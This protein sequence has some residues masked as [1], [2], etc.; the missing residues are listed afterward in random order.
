MT[1][2]SRRWFP[3]AILLLAQR[4]GTRSDDRDSPCERAS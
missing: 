2:M 4:A 1:F 3:L